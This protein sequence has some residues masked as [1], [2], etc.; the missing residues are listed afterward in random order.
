MGFDSVTQKYTNIIVL[1]IRYLNTNIQFSGYEYIC[2]S[3]S[4]NL[5]RAN[6]YNIRI[7]SGCEEQIHSIF[8]F[9]H[10]S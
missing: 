6:I 9:S 7:W 8:V 1:G 5:L 10:Q 2:Y 3:Y 4:S